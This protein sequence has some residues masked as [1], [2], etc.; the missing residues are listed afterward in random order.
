MDMIL[1]T[2]NVRNLYKTGSLIKIAKEITKYNLDLV[3][4][5]RSDGIGVASIQQA[6]KYFFMDRGMRIMN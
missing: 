3:E 1:I 4:Y 2:W 6:N 5:R